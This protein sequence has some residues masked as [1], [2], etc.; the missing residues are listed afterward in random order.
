MTSHQQQPSCEAHI[1]PFAQLSVHEQ[2]QWNRVSYLFLSLYIL[3][4]FDFFPTIIA[5]H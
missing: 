5:K 4:V 2:R 3:A 1:E